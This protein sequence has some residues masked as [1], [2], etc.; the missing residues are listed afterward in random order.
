MIQYSNK[1]LLVLSDEK[2]NANTTVNIDV[3]LMKSDRNDIKEI[4]KVLSPDFV[5]LDACLSS[6]RRENIKRQWQD[7]NVILIDLSERVYVDKC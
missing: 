2:I 6:M 7:F 4:Y 1:K 3:I 5:L